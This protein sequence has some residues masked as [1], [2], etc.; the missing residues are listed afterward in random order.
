MYAWVKEHGS[1]E[2]PSFGN[3]EI[4]KHLPKAWKT[5]E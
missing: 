3:I 1:K 5:K 2:S 4:E